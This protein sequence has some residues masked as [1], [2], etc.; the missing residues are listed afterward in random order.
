MSGGGVCHI[1]V[2]PGKTGAKIK[3]DRSD[4]DV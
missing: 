1:K 3:S 4:I 2:F